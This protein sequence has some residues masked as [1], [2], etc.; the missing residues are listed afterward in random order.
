MPDR[1]EF[2][3]QG[4]IKGEGARLPPHPQTRRKIDRTT[5][6]SLLVTTGPLMEGVQRKRVRKKLRTK[7]SPFSW[8][9]CPGN[10]APWR[11]R[12]VGAGPQT[13]ACLGWHSVTE[14]LLKN[15]PR[16]SGWGVVVDARTESS[17]QPQPRTSGLT[18]PAFFHPPS[19][20]LILSRHHHHRSLQWWPSFCRS[21]NSRLK[22]P[23]PLP[24]TAEL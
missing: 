13:E 16:I 4:G 24:S 14:H 23:L 1:P 7:W 3:L 6:D 17:W 21:L 22:R 10:S 9:I 11:G 12:G 8:T 15:H 2:P 20:R 5:G 18:P 19:H